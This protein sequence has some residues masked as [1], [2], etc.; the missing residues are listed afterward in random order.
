MSKLLTALIVSAFALAGAPVQAASH[1]AAAPA[2]SGAKAK[3]DPKTVAELPDAH[4]EG[5]INLDMTYWAE[6]RDE[7]GK[8][9]YDWQAK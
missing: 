7:I 1:A 5:Q 2:A 9:W 4:T 3:M 6:H 8:R